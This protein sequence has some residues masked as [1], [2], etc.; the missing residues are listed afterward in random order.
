[1]LRTTN[2]IVSCEKALAPRAT[3]DDKQSQI[4]F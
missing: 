3:N 2:D 1:M 4:P